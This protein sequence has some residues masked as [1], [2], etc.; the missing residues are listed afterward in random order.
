MSQAQTARPPVADARQHG[1]AARPQAM[2]QLWIEASN[3]VRA[4]PPGRKTNKQTN[5][6]RESSSTRRTDFF[7]AGF[8]SEAAARFFDFFGGIEYSSQPGETERGRASSR[9]TLRGKAAGGAA[10]AK[11]GADHRSRMYFTNP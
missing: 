4:L 1:D 6:A 2:V 9:G 7:A 5:V 11:S 8:F 10:G 3:M